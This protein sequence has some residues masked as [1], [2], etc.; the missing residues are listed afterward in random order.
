MDDQ[1]AIVMATIFSDDD[2]DAAVAF[3][4]SPAGQS[5]ALKEAAASRELARVSHDFQARVLLDL[6]RDFCTAH[7]EACGQFSYGQANSDA[8]RP[9]RK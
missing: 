9:K 4:E 3:A 2:L 1:E 6:S 8:G 5:M 7:G